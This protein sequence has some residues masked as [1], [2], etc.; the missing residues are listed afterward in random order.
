MSIY[1][2]INI[3]VYSITI[4]LINDRINTKLKHNSFTWNASQTNLTE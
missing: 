1:Y 4:T 2:R 3:L